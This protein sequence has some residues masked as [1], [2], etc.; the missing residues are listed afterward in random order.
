[1]TEPTLYLLDTNIIS[2]MMRNP[3]GVAAQR[4]LE[5]ARQNPANAMLTSVIVEC[6]LLFGLRRQTSP[7]W[8]QQYQWAMGSIEVLALE[9]QVAKTY[10]ELRTRLDE[11]G[12]PIGP[13]DTLIAAHALCLGAILVSADTEFTR[14]PGLSVENWLNHTPN[15]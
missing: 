10:A 9:P 12:T 5:K 2:H 6:E 8:Q 1:M 14:V 4:A 15:T 11:L 13:H 3:N 7:R